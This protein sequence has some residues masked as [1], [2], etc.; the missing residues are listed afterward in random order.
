MGSFTVVMSFSS[1]AQ[2]RNILMLL[3]L[4]A[5]LQTE[6]IESL[7]VDHSAGAE[8]SHRNKTLRHS[9]AGGNPVFLFLDS[10]SRPAALPG[11]TGCHERRARIEYFVSEQRSKAI[12]ARKRDCFVAGACPERSVAKSK[13]LLAMT[14]ALRFSDMLLVMPGALTIFAAKSVESGIFL[15]DETFF[16][17]EDL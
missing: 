7:R 10:G 2:E 16:L 6:G 11:M 3:L 9:R 17:S 1:S 15:N 8:R 12:F 4:R 14:L 13:G 5:R